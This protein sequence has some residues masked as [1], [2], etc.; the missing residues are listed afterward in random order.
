MVRLRPDSIC[1]NERMNCG[2]AGS[3]E[4]AAGT[5]DAVHAAVN[6]G[7]GGRGNTLRQLDL[8]RL[9]AGFC[10]LAEQAARAMHACRVWERPLSFMARQ[11]SRD[12]LPH[13]GHVVAGHHALLQPPEP[14]LH[15]RQR[16][17][18]HDATHS[19]P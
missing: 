14:D 18:Q 3:G 8:H 6:Q 17:A 11:Q 13:V 16:S 5:I 9:P 10:P 4:G 7:R 1:Q 12:G 2:G 19:A 15:E